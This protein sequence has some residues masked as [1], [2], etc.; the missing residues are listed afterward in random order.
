LVFFLRREP[1]YHKLQYSKAPRFDA[2]AASLGVVVGAF[3]VYLSL[4][5]FGSMG[6]DLTDLTIISWYLGLWYSTGYLL[7]SLYRQLG[8]HVYQT[9]VLVW[10]LTLEIFWSLQ[11]EVFF[12]WSKVNRCLFF[13]V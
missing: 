6:V 12:V 4:S 9:I 3:V 10:V 2:A 1:L 7:L 11:K 8:T 5:S 13:N